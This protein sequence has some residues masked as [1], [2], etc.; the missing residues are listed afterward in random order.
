[1]RF[2]K[3]NKQAFKRFIATGL[4]IMTAATFTGCGVNA[5]EKQTTDSYIETTIEVV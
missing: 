2:G 5:K 4:V 1:M 3:I